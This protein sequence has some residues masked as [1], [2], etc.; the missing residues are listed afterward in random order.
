MKAI[1]E[2]EMQN[3]PVKRFHENMMM[4]TEKELKCIQFP[5][6][7]KMVQFVCDS[8]KIFV[9]IKKSIKFVEKVK[10]INYKSK[11][12]PVVSV[13]ERGNGIEQLSNPFGVTVNNKT[14]DIYVVNQ[15]S[16]C[17][18]VFNDSGEFLFKFGDSNDTEQI[19]YPKGLIISG[20]RI[21]ISHSHIYVTSEHCIFIFQ[22]NGNFVSKFGKYGSG[23]IQFSGPRGLACNES[24]GDIYICDSGNNRIQIIT[25]ENQFKSQFGADKL[26][27]PHDVKLSKE[28]IFILDESN[29]CIHLY[30]YNLILQKS[31]VSRG[32]GMQVVN[33]FCF[34][35]DNSDN[36]LISDCGS[37][38]IHI[39]NPEVELIHKIKTSSRPMGVVVDNQG[40]VI[41]VCQ[42][43]KGCLQII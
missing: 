1:L 31:V 27:H 33:P 15:G 36:L 13:C 12:H 43:N 40:R 35:I 11:V 42:D 21:L 3:S 29:P 8:K 39:F 16:K 28:Y 24:N 32:K 38:S 10:S 2:A 34:F 26:K 20:D 19:K 25:K 41:V 6:E 23:N 4:Q 7:P 18:K 5:A 9:D 30:D 22:L 17:V 37:D 14:G